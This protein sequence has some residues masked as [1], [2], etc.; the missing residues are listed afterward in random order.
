M[1]IITLTLLVGISGFVCADPELFIRDDV[2]VI[3][4]DGLVLENTNTSLNDVL[5]IKALLQSI[6]TLQQTTQRI[7][8]DNVALQ[9]LTQRLIQDNLALQQNVSVW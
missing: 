3:V 9:Q 7:S 5:D 4:A 8:Q 6:T 2:L 1:F